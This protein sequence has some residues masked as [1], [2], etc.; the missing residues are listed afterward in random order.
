MV[1]H[2]AAVERGF[3]EAAL[4]EHGSELRNPIVDTA[5]LDRELRRL[6]R[7]ARGRSRADRPSERWLTTSGFPSTAPITPT[8]TP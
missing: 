8:A 4:A 2:V 5:V 7:R 3:L 6:R 1:A